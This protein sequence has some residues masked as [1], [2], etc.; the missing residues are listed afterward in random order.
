M[1]EDINALKFSEEEFVQ[2]I[3][4]NVK[5][6]LQ[7]FES[8]VLGKIMAKKKSNREAMY[9]VFKSLWFTKKETEV[10][11]S[12]LSPGYSTTDKDID[13]YEFSMSPFWL[14]VY[15]HTPGIHGST[16]CVGCGKSYRRTSMG[17]NR[18]EIIRALNYEKLP[19]FCYLCNLIGHT[20]KRCQNKV[21]GPESNML[22]LQYGS[23]MRATIVTTNHERGIWRNGVEVVTKKTLLNEDREESK[24]DTREDNGQLVQKRKR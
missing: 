12:T 19:D 2:V 24:T 20:T 6:N 7:G 13:T 17:R 10:E 14:R 8:W 18:V 9:R 5:N 23:L 15:K 21:E 22:D 3:S 11:S 16:N 4:N 1:A